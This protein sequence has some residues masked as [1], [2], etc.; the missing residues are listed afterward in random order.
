MVFHS[1]CIQTEFNQALLD[2]FQ[3]FTNFSL[4]ASVFLFFF[5]T[6]PISKCVKLSIIF[7]FT[8]DTELCID[9]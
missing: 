5:C 3:L 9:L 7:S 2:T 8:N 1:H 6:K 4:H